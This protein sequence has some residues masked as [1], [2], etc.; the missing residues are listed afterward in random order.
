MCIL[1]KNLTEIL[2]GC[3]IVLYNKDINMRL[4][5]IAQVQ[6]GYTFRTK[7]LPQPDA[8]GFLLQA[9]D[10]RHRYIQTSA[11]TPFETADFDTNRLLQDGD[12]VL[13][14][15][16]SFAVSV[17]RGWDEII[18]NSS[19]VVIR[20][21][22]DQII[23]EFLALVLSSQSVQKH[24]SSVSIG[25]YHRSIRIQDIRGLVL[26]DTSI[27]KQQEIVDFASNIA[28]QQEA[29]QMKTEYLQDLLQT[30]IHQ[31]THSL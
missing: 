20:P 4:D 26:P 16:L 17:Y 13:A 7:V 19:I 3:M 18:P 21:D 6:Q 31:I 22:Q 11:L 23:P 27:V 25:Q 29:Y 28:K 14:S 30:T 15:K 10:I 12:V 8:Q 5:S 2:K 24:F 1:Y 9:G